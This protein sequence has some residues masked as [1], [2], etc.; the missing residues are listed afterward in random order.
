MAGT[1]TDVGAQDAPARSSRRVVE[2]YTRPTRWFHAVTYLTVLVLLATGWWLASGQEGHPSPLS[3]LTGQP[4]TEIHT[5]V[6]WATSVFLGL[7]L[8][9]GVRAAITFTVESLRFRRQELGWFGRWPLAV[10]TGRFGRHEGHFDPGQ[11]I[12]NIVL[13]GLLT[14]LIASGIGLASLHG[15]PTFAVLVH[16]HRWATYAVTPVLA[17]HILIASG[18]LPGYRGV[19]RSMHLGGHLDPDVARR[20]WPGWSERV[21]ARRDAGKP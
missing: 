19:W 5:W 4:D 15:G 14:V 16:V 7:G 10:F 20:V 18:V 11:R 8:V 17:G 1:G 3:R 9:V 2:R 12:A 6:G 21:Q 13:V